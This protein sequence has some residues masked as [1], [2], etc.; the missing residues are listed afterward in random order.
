MSGKYKPIKNEELHSKHRPGNKPPQLGCLP[1][2]SIP[3]YFYWLSHVLR[4]LLLRVLLLFHL[5]AY[6]IPAAH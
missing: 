3:F 5:I 4:M 1:F 2:Q 6:R